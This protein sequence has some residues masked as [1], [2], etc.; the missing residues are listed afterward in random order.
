MKLVGLGMTVA[1]HGRR[2]AAV[3][4]DLPMFPLRTAN[5]AFMP[6]LWRTPRRGHAKDYYRRFLHCRLGQFCDRCIATC[7]GMQYQRKL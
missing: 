4:H 6:V 2:Y 3:N 7:L 1:A 5:R